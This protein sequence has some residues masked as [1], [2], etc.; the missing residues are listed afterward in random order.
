MASCL[1][2][3]FGVSSTLHFAA[4]AWL[5]VWGVPKPYHIVAIGRVWGELK[6][7]HIVAIGRVWGDLKP[8]FSVACRCTLTQTVHGAPCKKKQI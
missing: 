8:Q 6:P 5:A 2:L 4:S 1:E 7:C 3:L